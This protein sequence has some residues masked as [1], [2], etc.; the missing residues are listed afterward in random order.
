[1][2][3]PYNVDVPMMRVP[4][5][6]WALIAIT[7]LVSLAIVAGAGQNPRELNDDPYFHVM[8]DTIRAAEQD[9]LPPL[10]LVRSAFS[11]PQL[12]SYQF[13]H[14]DLFHLV[15][16]MIFLFVFGNAVNAKLGHVLFVAS[17]V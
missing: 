9:H 10:A 11:V 17:Y 8:D 14:A 6:N 15:G 16:N 5:A 7:T 4:F 13:V 3:L 1:M 12:I 2:L